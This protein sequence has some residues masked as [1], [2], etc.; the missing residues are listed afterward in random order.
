MLYVSLQ[1]KHHNYENI[2]KW[3]VINN[4]GSNLRVIT[5]DETDQYALQYYI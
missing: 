5:D 1:R 4:I 3:N 2:S